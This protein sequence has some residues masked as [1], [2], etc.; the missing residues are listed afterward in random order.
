M[1]QV[2]VPFGIGTNH[3]P[4]QA[5]V[6]DR[7]TYNVILGRDFLENYQAHIDL[8]NRVISLG[9][10][11]LPFVENCSGIPVMAKDPP[12]CFIH[13]KTSFIIPPH[14]EIIVPGEVHHPPLTGD[15]GIVEPRKEFID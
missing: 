13:A 6:L 1:G 7:M 3:F 2:N 5:L 15:I 12:I 9:T 11:Q 4:F 8:Q 10:A 14:S